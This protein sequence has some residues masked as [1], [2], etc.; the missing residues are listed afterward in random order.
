LVE[1]VD[2]HRL[3]LQVVP[4]ILTLLCAF[5][6]PCTEVAESETCTQEEPPCAARRDQTTWIDQAE[7]QIR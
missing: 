1:Q 2:L 3:H 7:R 4:T 6:P 5:T